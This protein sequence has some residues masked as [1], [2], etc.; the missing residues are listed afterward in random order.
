MSATY[1]FKCEFCRAI[2]TLSSMRESNKLKRYNSRNPIYNL[3]ISE[4]DPFPKTLYGLKAT[5]NE[6]N[7]AFL[8]LDKIQSDF[9]INDWDIRRWREEM[10]NREKVDIEEIRIQE[11][12]IQAEQT[13]KEDP[14]V[15]DYFKKIPPPFPTR[16]KDL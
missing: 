9:N 4:N 14:I 2:N 12:R 16:K 10:L 8:M 13:K 11:I 3:T 6:T 5:I 1:T 15:K 7:K